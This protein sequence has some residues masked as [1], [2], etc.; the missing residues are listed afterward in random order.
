VVPGGLT[1]RE[2]EVLRLLVAGKTDR[3][4]AAE[5]VLSEATVGR[6]VSNIY[7]KLN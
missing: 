7:N 1:H 5:L 2:V 4:I 6:H 3:Q